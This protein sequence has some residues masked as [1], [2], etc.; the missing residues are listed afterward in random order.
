MTFRTRLQIFLG[1]KD[2]PISNPFLYGDGDQRVAIHH[3]EVHSDLDTIKQVFIQRDYDLSRLKRGEELHQLASS[4]AKPLIIDAGANIGASVCWFCRD[5]PNAHVVAFEPDKSNF[6][7]MRR[8]TGGL[9]T[10]LHPT[11]IGSTD[12]TVVLVDPGLGQNAYRTSD[13]PHGTLRKESMTRI[14]ADKVAQGYAPLIA[15][16]DIEGGESE[17]FSANTEW[18]D[19]FPLVIVELHDWLLPKQGTARGFLQ[20]IA[21]KDR[22]F[23]HIG[24]NIFSIRN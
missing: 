24:E 13:N 17:L 16:V 4:M 18:V 11:A 9:H 1:L 14:V 19:L 22:D 5:F 10:D 23:A 6:E 2:P 7:L 21:S 15:K 8:N 3:R 12:G 20:C